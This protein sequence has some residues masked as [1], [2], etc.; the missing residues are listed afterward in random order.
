MYTIPPKKMVIINILEILK[1]YSDMD[2][3]LTQADIME[4]LNKEYYMDVDRKTVKRNLMNLLE[5]D[6]GIEYT[7]IPK[8]D[9]SGEE[10][11][12]YTDWYMVREFDDSELRLLIDSLLFSKHIPYSQCK[13][14]ISKLKGL[15]NVYFDEKVKHICNLPENQ[16][17]NKELFYT[18]DV[19]D[20]AISQKKQVSFIYNSYGADKKLHPK[21]EER[22]IVNPY[23]MVAT[24]GRYYLICNY[25]KYDDLSNYRI[26]RITGITMLDTPVKPLKGGINLPK[27]MAEHIYM[28]AG[29]SVRAKF[30]AKNYIIDQVIDWYGK[31]AKIMPENDEECI[32]TVS[33]NK[34]AFFCWAMQYGEHIEV[35]EPTDIREKI[36]S[37]VQEIAKKYSEKK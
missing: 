25:D 19:L 26:D 9:K 21:R 23:Q 3:R 37:S 27:H 16:P 24:N 30:R 31:D 6:C 22:Y 18:I 20:D 13:Q 34:N 28:F 2:H 29:D 17:E 5:L 10:S 7:E 11:S 14:L 33:V 32:V 1:K 12:I 4:K 8:K 36:I 15:S 35:L